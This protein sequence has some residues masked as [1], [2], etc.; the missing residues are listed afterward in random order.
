MRHILALSRSIILSEHAVAVDYSMLGGLTFVWLL[1]G[2]KHAGPRFLLARHLRYQI[3]V[4]IYDHKLLNGQ[5]LDLVN[6]PLPVVFRIQGGKES[7]S[8]FVGEGTRICIFVIHIILHGYKKTVLSYDADL[9]FSEIAIVDPTICLVIHFSLPRKGRQ[10][11]TKFMNLVDTLNIME[12]ANPKGFHNV[13]VGLIHA[14][15]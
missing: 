1:A 11:F 6:F 3:T 15:L 14:I 2:R 12:Y 4:I 10:L 7:V 8:F 9:I 13:I 5:S